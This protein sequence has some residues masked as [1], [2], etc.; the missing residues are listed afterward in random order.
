MTDELLMAFAD[1]QLDAAD[2]A[3]VEAAIAADGALAEKV[4]RLRQTRAAVHDAF[5]PVLDAPVPDRL[6]AAARGQ[7]GASR[8]FAQGWARAGAASAALAASFAIGV[9][10]APSLQKALP[11][12]PSIPVIADARGLT[13]DGALARALNTQPSGETVSG[14]RIAM[15]TAS[16][17]GGYCRAFVTTAA[18][19]PLEGVACTEN[20]DWRIIAMSEAPDPTPA[21]DGYATASG[22]L[23]AATLSA[24][25]AKRVGDPLGQDEERAVIAHG[26][27]GR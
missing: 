26:F 19:S 3:R 23:S 5:A 11:A 6:I 7:T 8:F 1:G 12:S 22:R 21:R 9:F 15:T 16:A 18:G 17:D 13:A 14:V 10:A 27:A 2:A 4:A 24:L 20:A 25:D